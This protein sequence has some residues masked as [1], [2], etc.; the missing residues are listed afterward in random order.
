MDAFYSIVIDKKSEQPLYQQLAEGL[1]R[2]IEQGILPANSKLPPIRYMASKLHVNVVTVVTAY[3]YLEQKK[4]VYSLVGSG[5][6]VSPLPIEQIE[7]PLVFQ[8]TK[9][10]ENE[11]LT[12]DTI[13]F[14]DTSMPQHLFPVEEFKEAFDTVL[15][16][17]KGNAF[18]YLDS[19]GYLPLRQILCQYL[20]EYSIHAAADNIQIISGAQQGI[21]IISKALVNY[22]DTIFTEKPTVYSACG[23]FLSRGGNVI[24]VSMEQDGINI[25]EL[26]NLLKVYHPK[27]LYIMA[28]FQTP[29]GISYSMDKKRKLLDLAEKYHFYIIEDDNLYDFYYGKNKIV[30]LKALDYKNKVIYIKSFS[31][32]WV[33]GLRMGFMLLPKKLLESVQ[34]AKYTTD[35]STSGFLQKGVEYYLRKYGW[36]YHSAVMRKYGGEQYRMAV[37]A[38][39]KHLG[40]K[41]VFSPPEGGIS[42]WL[43][44]PPKVEAELLCKMLLEQKVIVAPSSQYYMGQKEQESIRICFCNVKQMQLENGMKKIAAAIDKIDKIQQAP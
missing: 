9:L 44:L 24:T 22:G 14:V 2:M 13:N 41:V 40:Q 32:I 18:G 10:F 33:P 28:Y 25:A 8:Q 29:T 5:T 19:M 23:A 31:K 1:C 3:K 30:P 38:V 35:I 20:Q 15:E 39:K 16:R 11:I 26:E 34:S 6:Y 36:Q 42:L 7:K 12:E 17:E 37:S 21:D 27:F 43:K 4:V